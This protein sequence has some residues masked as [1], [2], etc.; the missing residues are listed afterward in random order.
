MGIIWSN[1]PMGE[2]NN[3]KSYDGN[4]QGKTWN[5]FGKSMDCMGKTSLNIV[6]GAM[7]KMGDVEWLEGF[8]TQIRGVDGG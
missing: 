3:G 1:E 7:L 2:K 8:I 5:V 6:H 4:I